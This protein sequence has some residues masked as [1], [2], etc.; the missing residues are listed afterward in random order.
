[1]F[2]DVAG[3]PG[4]RSVDNPFSL[5]PLMQSAKPLNPSIV[6]TIWDLFCRTEHVT[7]DDAVL[8]TVLHSK[9][10]ASVLSVV[11]GPPLDCFDQLHVEEPE[12]KIEIRN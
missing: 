9:V 4:A 6:L 10:H 3:V 8:K 12:E 1:V 2:P 7:V 5:D 11:L